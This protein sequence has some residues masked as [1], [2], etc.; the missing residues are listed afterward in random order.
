MSKDM[1]KVLF[2]VLSNIISIAL[3]LLASGM[4]DALAA[5]VSE[6]LK[7]PAVVVRE[8][9]EGIPTNW[10]FYA[11][12]LL[13]AGVWMAWRSTQY[14]YIRKEF[15][16]RRAEFEG[17]RE[18]G[19]QISLMFRDWR[20][21]YELRT[22]AHVLRARAD[23][24]LG[25]IFLLSF[26]VIY[27]VLFVLPQILELDR[28]LAQQTTQRAVFEDRYGE[29]LQLLIDG[30]YWLK[31]ASVRLEDSESSSTSVF[32]F[33]S[34]GRHGLVGD[35]KGFLRV[36][37]D[38][39]ETWIASRAPLEAEDGVIGA[40]F[41]E[42]RE[43]GVLVAKTGL[44]AITSDGGR[45]WKL[46]TSQPTTSELIRVAEFSESGTQ[47]LLGD[48]KGSVAVTDDKGENWVAANLPVKT[49][50]RVIFAILS[51]NTTGSL[52]CG[53]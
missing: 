19:S 31:T 12:L 24:I 27:I 48:F 11:V 26:G 18:A 6:D 36:T 45:K 5:Q 52:H 40:A 9:L 21:T 3:V 43:V 37:F 51:D 23:V 2:I 15:Y 30:R 1:G 25:G 28:I 42:N 20:A 10:L 17:E 50:E 4:H 46:P 34:D 44:V 14:V 53:R 33:S 39:G 7:A 8:T 29:A 47:G 32:D 22:R 41:S 49:G 16:S 38:G 35:L 13:I